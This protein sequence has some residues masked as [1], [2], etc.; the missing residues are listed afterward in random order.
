MSRLC[1][2][3]QTLVHLLQ[4]EHKPIQKHLYH[5]AEEIQNDIGSNDAAV[6]LTKQALSEAQDARDTARGRLNEAEEKRLE[7]KTN[8]AMLTEKVTSNQ[9]QLQLKEQELNVLQKVQENENKEFQALI[10]RK[11][12][13]FQVL[14]QELKAVQNELTLEE[15]KARY[16]Q[17]QFQQASGE[18]AD[19]SARVHDLEREQRKLETQLE[20]ERLKAGQLLMLATAAS[21]SQHHQEIEVQCTRM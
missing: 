2:V 4:Q 8:V 9:R 15:E 21:K 11:N 1:I 14:Q 17:E 12:E 6:A 20:I 13:E 7:A 18:L 19:K 5:R 10:K 3:T 16:F